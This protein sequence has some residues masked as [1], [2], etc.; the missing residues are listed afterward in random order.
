ML[1]Q[2]VIQSL[3]TVDIE[4]ICHMISLHALVEFEY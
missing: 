1:I 2:I 4:Y 3:T